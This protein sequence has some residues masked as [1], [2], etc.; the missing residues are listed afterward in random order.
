MDEK[1]DWERTGNIK[2]LKLNK[3]EHLFQLPSPFHCSL[4][5]FKVISRHTNPSRLL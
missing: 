5:P 3:L 4:H 2:Y 1:W